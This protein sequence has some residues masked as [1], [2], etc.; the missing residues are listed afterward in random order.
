[1]QTSQ[2]F[3]QQVRQNIYCPLHTHVVLCTH[4]P[5]TKAML[6][7]MLYYMSVQCPCTYWDNLLDI[8]TVS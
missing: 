5:H 7:V 2:V 1:M 8:F 3:V 6:R 4:H